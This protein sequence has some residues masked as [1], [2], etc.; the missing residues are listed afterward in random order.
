MLNEVIIAIFLACLVDSKKNLVD[1]SLFDYF[2]TKIKL[3]A[4]LFPPVYVISFFIDW[5]KLLDGVV[6]R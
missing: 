5:N 6:L 1:V 2:K 3:T 4:C